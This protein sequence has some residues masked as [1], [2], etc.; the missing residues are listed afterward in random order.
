[1]NS[2]L[3]RS[4]GLP[5]FEHIF[6]CGMA[7]SCSLTSCSNSPECSAKGDDGERG[8][9]WYGMVRGESTG[10]YSD[11]NELHHAQ[12]AAEGSKDPNS[13]TSCNGKEAHLLGPLGIL[14]LSRI[15][16]W[17][18]REVDHQLNATECLVSHP[19]PR[20]QQP[21]HRV[22]SCDCSGGRKRSD[23]WAAIGRGRCSV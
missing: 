5:A 22:T 15:R 13:A 11:G 17:W 20:A 6:E 21:F 7:A 2:A 23:S 16:G 3:R 9:S 10:S 18:D 14:F 12:S 4:P 19:K 8:I 1:V